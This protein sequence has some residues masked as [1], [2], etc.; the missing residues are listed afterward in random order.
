M[1]AYYSCCA[2]RQ[3][4]KLQKE[5]QNKQNLIIE[6]T[7]LLALPQRHKLMHTYAQSNLKLAPCYAALETCLPTHCLAANHGQ[8]L[9]S[10]SE[11]MAGFF[12][13]N[14]VQGKAKWQITARRCSRSCHLSVASIVTNP[15]L[16]AL[17]TI[18]WASPAHSFIKSALC[19]LKKP[20][21]DIQ[22]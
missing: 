18:G 13:L 2:P 17:T 5:L 15:S 7:P 8:I 10:F 4:R 3:G 22:R 21:R 19:E 9:M 1:S 20:R 11:L 6:L 16:S 12:L 14:S